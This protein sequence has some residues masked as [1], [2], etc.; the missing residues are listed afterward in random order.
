M[1][2]KY[3]MVI[4]DIAGETFLVP[5]GEAARKF[6]GMFALNELGAF[7][8]RHLEEAETTENLVELICREYDVS[9]EEAEADTKE[10]LGQLQ[11][12]GIL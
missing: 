3:E 6:P 4:R 11:E 7:T 2:L 12:M 10:F 8:Y 5:I 1:K 9:R